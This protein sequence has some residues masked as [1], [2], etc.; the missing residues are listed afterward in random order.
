MTLWSKNGYEVSDKDGYVNMRQ[1][2]NSSSTI[3]TKLNNGTKLDILDAS[4]NWWKVSTEGKEGFI[5]KSRI[6]KM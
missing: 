1:A 2:P 4:S 5:H 6:Q 3:V